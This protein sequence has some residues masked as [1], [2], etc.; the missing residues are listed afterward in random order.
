[1][2]S[3]SLLLNR[4]IHSHSFNLQRN[5]KIIGTKLLDIQFSSR[6]H[7]KSLKRE[8]FRNVSSIVQP[9]YSGSVDAR[10]ILGCRVRTRVSSNDKEFGVVPNE[11]GAQA[12]NFVEFITSERVKV[13]AM[14]AL[15]L[16]LCNADRVV[17]SVAIVPLS[18]AN[19]WSR[20][21]AGIVQVVFF[22]F[23]NMYK[24]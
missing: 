20:S 19:G 18:L 2:S 17:M 24:P 14:L 7:N 11:D 15:A 1:M 13:V 9:G 23:G 10:T 5:R 6:F 8:P 4:P 21:F 16:A 12:S 22:L 3:S